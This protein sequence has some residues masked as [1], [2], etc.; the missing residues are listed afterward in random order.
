MIPQKS[1][2]QNRDVQLLVWFMEHLHS[3]GI[4]AKGWSLNLPSRKEQALHWIK[5]SPVLSSGVMSAMS[6]RRA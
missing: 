6:S 1:L 2:D 3:R 4:P 5:I